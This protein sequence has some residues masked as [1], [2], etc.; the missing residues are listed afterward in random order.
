MVS[1]VQENIRS[2][3]ER[4]DKER[5]DDFMS[6][7]RGFVVN[8]V[9]SFYIGNVFLDDNNAT[10]LLRAIFG[11]D[12]NLCLFTG[13]ICREDGKRVG[14]TRRRNQRICERWQLK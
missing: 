4:H 9:P 14:D 11:S 2:E 5:H 12:N 6:M 3:L 10:T 1:Y 13:G 8:Q 7:L